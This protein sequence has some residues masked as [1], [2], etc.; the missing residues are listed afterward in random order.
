MSF[1]SELDTPLLALS[2]RDSFTLRD[3]C[4]GV[5]VFG[6]IGSGKTSG[7]GH[8]LAG[9]YLR[10][11][12]GGLVLCAKP[13]EVDLWL[14]YAKEHGRRDSV[15]VFDEQQG[16]N[17]IEYELGR[18]GLRGISNVTECLLRILDSADNVMGA[19]GTDS[20]PFWEQ[21]TRMALN[22][23]IPALYSA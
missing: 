7:T 9:A 19:G 5:H 22:Y 11:G 20:N 21:S 8:T 14:A 1:V 4:A 23:S 16:F 17:F 18:H 10:A 12:M 3:A 15:I 13:E 6:G 2:D